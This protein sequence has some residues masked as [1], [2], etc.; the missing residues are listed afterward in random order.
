MRGVLRGGSREGVG[1][2][3][4]RGAP[5]RALARY[6]GPGGTEFISQ[7]VFIKSTPTKIRQ[8]ILYHYLYQECIDEFVRKLAFA[9]R[10]HK[11]FL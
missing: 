4:P 9:E 6:D 10:L 2:L 8:L 1:L 5:G 11:H 3:Q 7:K